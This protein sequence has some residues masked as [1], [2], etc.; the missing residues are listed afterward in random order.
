MNLDELKA[1]PDVEKQVLRKATRKEITQ[2]TRLYCRPQ[3]AER[4][5][6]L[7]GYLE[8]AR[9]ALEVLS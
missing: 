5:A 9:K 6:F 2:A 8:H 4:R 1:L 7:S 3:T